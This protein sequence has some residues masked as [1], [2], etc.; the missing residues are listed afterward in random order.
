MKHLHRLIVTSSA[1]R[2]AS[3]RRCR[4]PARGRSRQSRIYW[5]MDD[6][7]HG[8]RGGARQRAAPGRPAR[9]HDGRPRSIPSRTGL[10]LPRRSLYF[11]HRTREAG[12]VPALFDAANVLECYRRSESIVPQQAL[13][14]ANSRWCW[15]SAPAGGLRRQSARA[16]ETASDRRVRRRRVRSGARPAASTAAEQAECVKFL[17]DRPLARPKL[18]P[19]ATAAAP[20]RRRRPAL[21]PRT[22]S[23]CC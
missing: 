3:R 1:Y 10:N 20:V 17:G 14:L 6:R 23:T 12:Q 4:P 19:L 2:M 18:T 5:R 8:G 22:W 21:A 9:L 7:A 11:A 16:G 15:R 13:A